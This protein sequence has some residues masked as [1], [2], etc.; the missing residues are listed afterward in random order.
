MKT[1]QIRF[2]PRSFV[3]NKI[4]V[5]VSAVAVDLAADFATGPPGA[6]NVH[7]SRARAYGLD[8]LVHLAGLQALRS[9]R[10]RGRNIWTYICGVDRA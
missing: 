2:H 7:R 5:L 3:I 6:V 4:S 1:D 9:R 10:R 8:Q